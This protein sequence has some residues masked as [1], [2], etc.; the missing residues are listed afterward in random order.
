M[1]LHCTIRLDFRRSLES[2]LSSSPRRVQGKSAGS[3]PEQRLVIE[4]ISYSGTP[5]IRS[6]TGHKI[7][8]VLRANVTKNRA[9][10]KF[11]G[12]SRKIDFSL[13]SSTNS[14]QV[15][16]KRD[17]VFLS[18]KRFKFEKIEFSP[19]PPRLSPKWPNA[20]AENQKSKLNFRSRVKENQNL[21]IL[22]LERQSIQL[23]KTGQNL[24]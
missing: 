15:D 3:F 14:P 4:P 10:F 6:P 24:T 2:G 17:I 18:S 9:K 5:L 21:S 11:G 16:M 13:F 23:S 19:R 20:K 12:R 8:D 1:S 22:F 7:L